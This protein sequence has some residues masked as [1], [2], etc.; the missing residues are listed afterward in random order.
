VLLLVSL[1]AASQEYFNLTAQQVRIDSMLP[2]FTYAF[3]L[4]SH[5]ADSLY[6]VS[7]AYPEF[8]PMSE[9][10][11]KRY[12]K[13]S[14]EVLP[15]L[16]EITQQ[17]SISR[18]KAQLEVSFVPLVWRD[19]KYQKLVSFQL[20]RQAKALPQA[21]RVARREETTGGTASMLAT[22][23]WAKIRVAESGIFQLTDD[24]LRRAGFTNSS[25]VH[26]YGY[27]GA[28]QPEKLSSDYIAAT[29]DLRQDSR[30][31]V[32]HLPAD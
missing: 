3:P 14:G 20:K 21:R 13:I 22:G 18:K 26:V 2:R 11:V 16:P 25:K 10:D 7:I 19:G 4:D 30:R 24:L 1:N 27:G 15:M 29:D 17:I 5:Y 8:L 9:A 6:S 32:G 23:R 31:R 28:L 12:E